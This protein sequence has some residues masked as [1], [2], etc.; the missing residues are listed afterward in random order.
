MLGGQTMPPGT[1]AAG[2]APDGRKIQVG[3]LT[4]ALWPTPNTSDGNGARTPEQVAAIRERSATRETSGGPAGCSA[5]REAALW[6]TPM[7]GGNRKS[8]RAL[9]ASESNGR[10]A[11]GGQS[12]PLGLEQMIEIEAGVVPRE[13]TMA[14]PLPPSTQAALGALWP[15]PLTVNRTSDRAKHGRPTAGPSR[16]GAS[17]G[18]EDAVKLWPT[19]TATPYGSGQNGCPHDGRTEYAGRGAP[20]LETLVRS[21]LWPTP[22]AADSHQVSAHKGGNPSLTGAVLWPTPTATDAKASGSAHLSTESGRHAGT[23]LTDAAVKNWPT[24]TLADR[25][26]ARR[27]ANAQGGQPLSEAV[28]SPPS[29]A[30]EPTQQLWATPAARDDHGPTGKGYATKGKAQLPN[31]VLFPTPTASDGAAG[32]GQA[33]SAEGAPNLRTAVRWATPRARDGRGRSPR[34]GHG[35]DGLPDQCKVKG[36]SALNPAWVEALMGFPVGWTE[37]PSEPSPVVGPRAEASLKKAGSR[38]AR[39]RADTLDDDVA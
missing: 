31:Q 3:L 6:A 20:S 2:T 29:D 10:R 37:P 16:G 27:G 22:G 39:S 26:G 11:G 23:T 9:T 32:P 15:T 5:L 30:T 1:T 38:R 24:P 8:A 18:L 17:F 19:P 25:K 36:G 13:V 14:G 28:L 34:K 4:A 33:S 7:T 35:G 21:E 12:S